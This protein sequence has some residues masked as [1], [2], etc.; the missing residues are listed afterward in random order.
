MV[1]FVTDE[2]L[3]RFSHDLQVLTDGLGWMFN[4]P[5]PRV[6]FGEFIRGLMADVPKKNGRGLADHAGHRSP[7]SFQHLLGGAKWDADVLRDQVSALVV[8]GLGDPGAV[9]VIDD[10]QVLKKGDKSVGVA[11]QHYGLTGDTRNCQTMVMLTYASEHGHAFIDRELYLPAEWAGDAGRRKEAGVPADRQFATKPQLAIAMLERATARGVPFS[12]IADDAGYG[13]D[14]GLRAWC[15]ERSRKYV[16]AVPK[17]LPLVGVYGQTTRADLVHAALPAG[18]WQR[19]SQGRGAKGERV[20]DWAVCAVTVKDQT[21]GD[22]FEHVLLVR[23]TREPVLG[24][25]GKSRYE[26]A[27]FLAHAPLGTPAQELIRVAG[28]RWRIEENNCQGKDLFGL[29]G[30]QVRK[31]TSWHRHV[32]SCTLVLAFLAVKRA[33]LGKDPQLRKEATV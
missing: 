32:T 15:H 30:Y 28:Q 26:F 10:T 14:P 19:R 21:P 3:S 4:R 6:V 22:G 31:W 27:Y 29:D 1:D 2:D 5:E 18:I 9:L 12:W 17:S 13:K 20:Y 11:P 8:Q 33:E 23:K 24:R 7:R 16:M 25:D